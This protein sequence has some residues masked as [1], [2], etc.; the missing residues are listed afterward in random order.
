MF[1]VTMCPI[2]A[3]RRQEGAVFASGWSWAG[4]RDAP[5]NRKE[6]IGQ[7]HNQPACSDWPPRFLLPQVRSETYTRSDSKH[8]DGAFLDEPIEISPSSRLTAYARRH[9]WL[10]AQNV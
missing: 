9:G 5:G 3:T 8:H 6:P 4:G 7:S 10:A 2:L 1:A